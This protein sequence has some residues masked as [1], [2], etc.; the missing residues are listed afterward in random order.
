MPLSKTP[1]NPTKDM[2]AMAIMEVNPSGFSVVQLSFHFTNNFS[3]FDIC[4]AFDV[5]AALINSIFR[6]F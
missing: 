5:K 2:M 6:I 3:Q 1:T 4:K